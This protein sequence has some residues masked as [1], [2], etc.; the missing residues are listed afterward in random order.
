[1]W[2]WNASKMGMWI[3]PAAFVFSMGWRQCQS[4]CTSSHCSSML[5]SSKHNLHDWENYQICAL[6][7]IWKL[8]GVITSFHRLDC[9][10]SVTCFDPMVVACTCSVF[11]P[12]LL[13]NMLEWK[14]KLGE[15]L[16]KHSSKNSQA[17]HWSHQ[18]PIFWQRDTS[19]ED[20]Q[21]DI[22]LELRS[23]PREAII[24]SYIERLVL[25]KK[26]IFGMYLSLLDSRSSCWY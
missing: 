17:D 12:F 4:T 21:Y 18:M 19:M 26:N 14:Y 24:D 10:G 9:D 1:M 8:A 2:R 23:M 7:C 20:V 25:I 15:N 11:M 13:R 3:T 5:C 22:F 16:M 6:Q